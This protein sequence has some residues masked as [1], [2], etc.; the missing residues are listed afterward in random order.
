[1]GADQQ[2]SGDTLAAR[3][4]RRDRRSILVVADHFRIDAQLDQLVVLAC[5]Q[6]HAMQ[7]T[8]MHDR[9]G[10]AEPFAKMLA[11]IDV[12]DL[13]RRQRIHQPQL[14]DIDGHAARGLADAEIV[15]GMKGVGPELDA[16]ADLAKGSGLFPQDRA[17]ALL[18]KAHRGREPSDAAAGNQHGPLVRRG[19]QPC[20]PRC[21]SASSARSGTREDSLLRS[22]NCVSS[23]SSVLRSAAFRGCSIRASARSTD[24]LMSRSPVAPARVRYSSLTRLSPPD[25]FRSISFFAS[26]RSITLPSVE[27]SKAI[28]AESRVASMPGW[29]WIATSAAYCTG[30]RSNAR[31]SSTN[32]ATAICCIRRNR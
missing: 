9:V 17:K 4:P 24:G 2:R 15:E 27:R 29:V 6:K 30:V 14:I 13:F 11:Q 31:H 7:V 5:P 25:G 26:S 12:G 22:T 16:G 23:A 21:S 28:T 8:A 18:A 20:F 19:H 10:I 32:S 3:E 1:M